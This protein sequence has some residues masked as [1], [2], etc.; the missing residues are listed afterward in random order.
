[1]KCEIAQCWPYMVVAFTTGFAVCGIG[2]SFWFLLGIR[3]PKTIS[4]RDE[5]IQDIPD[6]ANVSHVVR[7]V[8]RGTF[9]SNDVPSK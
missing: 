4:V 5:R 2:L 8:S 3:K 1:M 6:E 9:D 7:G